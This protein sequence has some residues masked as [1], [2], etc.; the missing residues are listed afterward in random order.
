MEYNTPYSDPALAFHSDGKFSVRKGCDN[1]ISIF[2]D[3]GRISILIVSG[4]REPITRCVMVSGSDPRTID[5]LKFPRSDEQNV[6]SEIC[7][8]V[9]PVGKSPGK[10][11][12]FHSRPTDR[13]FSVLGRVAIYM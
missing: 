8:S 11:G 7:S 4:K 3:L 12:W 9:N 1:I 13:I 2:S 10:I 6:P 5:L